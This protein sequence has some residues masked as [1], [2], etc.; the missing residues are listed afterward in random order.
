MHS[1]L[2]KAKNEASIGRHSELGIVLWFKRNEKIQSELWDLTKLFDARVISGR[3]ST[4]GDRGFRDAIIIRTNAVQWEK[5]VHDILYN[6]IW[7]TYLK[8]TLWACNIGLRARFPRLFVR[9]I[10]KGCNEVAA[11]AASE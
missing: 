11:Q 6:Q 5:I 4:C 8:R 2:T 7:S 9:Q 10:R 3:Y 1:I